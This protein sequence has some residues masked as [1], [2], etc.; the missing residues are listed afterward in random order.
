[1]SWGYHHWLRH[2]RHRHGYDDKFEYMLPG[3]IGGCIIRHD[4]DHDDEIGLGHIHTDP[5][6]L[7][8]ME[9]V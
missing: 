8:K 5:E 9:E 7:D 6:D 2:L 3:T 4:L 1:M